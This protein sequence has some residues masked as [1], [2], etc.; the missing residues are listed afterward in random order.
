MPTFEKS[1]SGYLKMWESMAIR[2]AYARI[3]GAAAQRIASMSRRSAYNAVSRKTGVPW[4]WIGITH[5]LEAA[6]D[7]GR[8]L[9]NG[10][11]LS[12]RTRQVPKNRP[13]SGS[14]PFT[15]EE[16]AE[17]ALRLHDLHLVRDWTIPRAL[18]EFERYNGW[19]YIS[20]R[21]NS[22]YLWSFS[23]H[24]SKGKYVADGKF[25]R[26]AVSSQVGAA[27]LLRCLIDLE[28]ISPEAVPLPAQ[29]GKPAR[30]EPKP[31][32]LSLILDLL[33]KVFS[34]G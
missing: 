10:D 17:D 13:A 23:T 12:A 22:P 11:P 16:S 24:Y 26:N 7:F 4:W 27:V 32:L 28:L 9:H 29:Q 34:R 1:Q 19:G 25:D 8:H 33:K 30:A 15:W 31:S 3:A 20:R 21:I 14:P 2:P 6:G 18:Y 5:E